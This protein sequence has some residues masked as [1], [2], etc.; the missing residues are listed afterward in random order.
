MMR[1]FITEY[2]NYQLANSPFLYNSICESFYKHRINIAV[3]KY[4]QGF[5]TTNEA[6]EMILRAEE[7][8]LRE[9]KTE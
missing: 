5:I 1:R 9:A 4:R 8:A 7:Y 2:A 3:E 6:M